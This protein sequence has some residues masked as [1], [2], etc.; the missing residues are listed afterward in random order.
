[1][2]S[3]GGVAGSSESLADAIDIDELD[4]MEPNDDLREWVGNARAERHRMGYLGT[5]LGNERF[6]LPA[7][8]VGDEG[9][10]KP[11]ARSCLELHRGVI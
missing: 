10:A 7:V 11:P 8:G 5:R 4:D 1:M 6:V 9:E 3:N 2:G